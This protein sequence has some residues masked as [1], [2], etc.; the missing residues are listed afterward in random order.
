MPPAV[1][2]LSLGIFAMTTSEFMVSGMMPSLAAGFGVSVA[3]VGYLVSAYAAGMVVGGPLLTVALLKVPR[4]NALLLLTVI[5]LVGTVLGAVATD[6]AVMAVAR[7]ITGI[8]SSAF[9]GV[10]LAL[11]ADLVGPSL[12]GRASSV[13]LGGLMVGTVLGLPAATLLDQHLGWRA[14]F[15]MVAALTLVAGSA[16]A[17]IVPDLPKAAEIGLRAELGAFRNGRLWA[18][19]AVSGLTIG[20][21]FAAFS[22]FT[23]IYLDVSGFAAGVVPLLLAVYGVAT[24]VGT[25]VVGRLADR[26]ATRTMAVGLAAIAVSLALFG[27]FAGDK[28]VA[29][30]CTVVLGL[31]G[32]SLNPAMV[33]RVM[34]AANDRPLVNTVHTAVINVGIMV[35]PW[36]GGL[37]ITA[38]FGLTA[39]LWVGVGL[40]V[41]GLSAVLFRT[42]SAVRPRT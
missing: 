35:G 38:G 21:V 37:A 12:R 20:S 22:Y 32:V 26:H 31:V 41:L 13:V 34:R 4:K 8:A 10:A 11:C 1:Y 36:V 29:V 30:L 5:F 2:V 18:A 9:F 24:V 16:I 6:Y 27:L 15:W 23:P 7:V 33:T 25:A 14:A 28:A 3:A 42:S 39:P 17:K 40:A 19:Y